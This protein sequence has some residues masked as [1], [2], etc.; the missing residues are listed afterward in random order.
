MHLTWLAPSRDESSTGP[1]LTPEAI[2]IWAAS[3]AGQPDDEAVT[4]SVQGGRERGL[5]LHKLFEEVLTG[6]TEDDKVALTERARAL[7]TAIGKPVVDDAAQG[8]SPDELAG[9]VTRALT[10]S[11]I[12]EIR[13]RPVLSAATS[14]L[15]A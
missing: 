4:P 8:L 9:C 1:V 11:E 13:L 12:A 7:I 6:E 2:E 15:G 14:A 5:I 3:E 10:L